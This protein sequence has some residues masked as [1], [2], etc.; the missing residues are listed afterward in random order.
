[1]LGDG[2]NGIKAGYVA[3]CATIMIPDLVE[4]SPDIL[5]YYKKICRDLLQAKQEIRGMLLD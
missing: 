5:P 1:M 2:E 4:A 3:G